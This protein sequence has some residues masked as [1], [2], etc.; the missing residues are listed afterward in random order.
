MNYDELR[1]KIESAITEIQYEYN[2]TQHVFEIRQLDSNIGEQMDKAIT[3][4]ADCIHKQALLE[5]NPIN[6]HYCEKDDMTFIMQ[7]HYDAGILVSQECIGWYYG[8]PNAESTEIYK[9]S[10]KADY[11]NQF[12]ERR[13]GNE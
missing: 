7:S 3:S 10:L 11:N 4:L 13:C 8:K 5:Q 1:K 6:T 12:N 2:K 9:H